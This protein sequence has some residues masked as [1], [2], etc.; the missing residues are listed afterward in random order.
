[1]ILTAL[2][3]SSSAQ[4][5]VFG[6]L[7][8]QLVRWVWFKPSAACLWCLFSLSSCRFWHTAP[9]Q[10]HQLSR[11][12]FNILS[13][14]VCVCVCLTL[15]I[16]WAWCVEVMECFDN[17][18]LYWFFFKVTLL[19]WLFLK[20]QKKRRVLWMLVWCCIACFVDDTSIL[21]HRMSP[22]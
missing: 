14:C 4:M 17:C 19:W 2:L 22:S 10:R 15:R 6:L 7:F 12:H 8:I 9:L 11:L 13:H 3:L 1:M 16:Y 5:W 20:G 21:I 18:F